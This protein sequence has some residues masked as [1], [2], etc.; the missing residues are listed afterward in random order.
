MGESVLDSSIEKLLET[1]RKTSV[2]VEDFKLENQ[3]RVLDGLQQV[4]AELDAVGAVAASH[5]RAIRMPKRLW[6]FVDAGRNPQLF[7]KQ[8]VADA[9]RES[10]VCKGKVLALQDYYSHLRRL[11]LQYFPELEAEV[12]LTHVPEA[13]VGAAAENQEVGPPELKRQKQ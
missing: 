7:T 12:E 13:E 2:L 11:T 8:V 10:E 6:D 1:L 5:G 9:V 3:E 4:A